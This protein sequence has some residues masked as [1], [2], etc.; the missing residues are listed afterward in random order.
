MKLS[1]ETFKE[2]ESCQDLIVKT[3]CSCVLEMQ[4]CSDIKVKFYCSFVAGGYVDIIDKDSTSVAEDAEGAGG[5]LASTSLF[6]EMAKKVAETPGLAGKVK[7]VFLWNI[8]KNKAV[9]V[10][11]SKFF[12]SF[13]VHF[14]S[15]VKFTIFILITLAIQ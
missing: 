5:S 6:Q 10:Q 12:I 8:T 3:Y 2:M 15:L 4:N 11:W 7:A 1:G 14:V 13:A 9:A